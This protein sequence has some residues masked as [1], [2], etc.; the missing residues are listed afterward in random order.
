M[1]NQHGKVKHM[2]PFVLND[3]PTIYFTE[4]LT[5]F[6]KWAK[7]QVEA[8]LH[9]FKC[10]TQKCMTV[11]V[12]ASSSQIDLT[13]EIQSMINTGN[14]TYCFEIA[15]SLSSMLISPHSPIIHAIIFFPAVTVIVAV[16]NRQIHIPAH[17][18]HR[19]AW[20]HPRNMKSNWI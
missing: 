14:I 15:M 9:K 13:R 19:P 3:V 6:W 5:S 4:Q 2:K 11:R 20:V 8:N 12:I 7:Y 10:I 18:Q 16:I 1:M 17:I